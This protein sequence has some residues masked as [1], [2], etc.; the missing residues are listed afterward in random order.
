MGAPLLSALDKGLFPC[1]GRPGARVAALA[2]LA[3]LAAVL[4]AVAPSAARAADAGGEPAPAVSSL[5]RDGPVAAKPWSTTA[6]YA[7]GNYQWLATRGPLDFSL[8]FDTPG[9]MSAMVADT[10][11]PTGGPFVQTLPTLS[12]DLRDVDGPSVRGL[13]QAEHAD[14]V[15][16]DRRVGIQWKPAES[17]LLFL[18]QGLGVR[19]S[20]DD[21]FTMRLRKGT[22]SVYMKREF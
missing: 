9:R 16:S 22:L 6:R 15:T 19:L 7:G 20:G 5:P 11:L 10:R 17:Q 13:R 3:V 12:L 14:T 18:R 4:A 8:G 1:R 21:R 2:I